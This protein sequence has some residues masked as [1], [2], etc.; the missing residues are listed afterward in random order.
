MSRKAV[1]ES[2]VTGPRKPFGAA[3]AAPQVILEP[4][5]PP[6][7]RRCM[8]L[9]SLWR[10]GN[11][12]SW[13]GRRMCGSKTLGV[14]DPLRGNG[15]R[16]LAAWGRAAT[17][18]TAVGLPPSMR[19]VLQHRL[20]GPPLAYK[21]RELAVALSLA[22]LLSHPYHHQALLT[23]C[24]ALPLSPRARSFTPQPDKSPPPRA[25]RSTT[26]PQVVPHDKSRPW[27]SSL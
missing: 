25:L 16:R 11:T 20:L 15:C 18:G 26:D 21:D 23:T 14:P 10:G 24:T 7:Q 22:S 5:S 1:T 27:P 3:A 17:L 9:Y 13:G 2:P 12:T 6:C 4:A 19:L 8:C